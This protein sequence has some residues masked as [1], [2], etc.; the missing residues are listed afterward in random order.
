[1]LLL[2]LLSKRLREQIEVLPQT[3]RALGDRLIDL[4]CSVV[5]SHLVEARLAHC[6][7]VAHCKDSITSNLLD[8]H[9]W[10]SVGVCA[11]KLACTVSA[12]RDSP[13]LLERFSGAEKDLGRIMGHNKGL[14]SVAHS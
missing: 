9:H 8:R 2:R 4:G 13:D 7:D 10:L 5:Y 1:M 12:I 14:A 6:K 11:L 3:T